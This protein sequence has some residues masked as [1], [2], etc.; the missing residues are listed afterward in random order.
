MFSFKLYRILELTRLNKIS[1]LTKYMVHIFL[2]YIY[3][4]QL[5]SLGLNILVIGN[6]PS[7]KTVYLILDNSLQLKTISL[8]I[9]PL[10]QKTPQ[11]F[12]ES[13]FI[14]INHLFFKL[15]NPSSSQWLLWPC[16]RCLQHS[17]CASL[18]VYSFSIAVATN[19]HKLSG[20]K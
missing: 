2:L 13:K 18:N 8:L 6:S 3:A 1:S 10:Q 7:L 17:E 4:K 12:K 20:F 11:I 19:Y 9:L 15:N 16:F 14:P 5:P